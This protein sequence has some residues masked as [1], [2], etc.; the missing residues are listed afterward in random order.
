M[1]LCVSGPDHEPSAGLFGAK[2]HTNWTKGHLLECFRQV[3]WLK[4]SMKIAS[5]K[6]NAFFSVTRSDFMCPKFVT[7]HEVFVAITLRMLGL[8]HQG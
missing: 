8:V 5:K 6:R 2:K 4:K 3:C 1:N 7:L